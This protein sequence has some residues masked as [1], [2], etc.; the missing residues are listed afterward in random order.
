MPCKHLTTPGVAQVPHIF[1]ERHECTAVSALDASTR[2]GIG[3]PHHC[4][5]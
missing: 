4:D 2:A 1:V 5:A 3:P